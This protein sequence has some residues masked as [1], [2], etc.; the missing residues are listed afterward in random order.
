MRGRQTRDIFILLTVLL[1]LLL[2]L[3]ELL[4][5][6]NV[7][8]LLL[9]EETVDLLLDFALDLLFIDFEQLLMRARVSLSGHI[10]PQ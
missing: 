10:A 3:P 1:L 8:G 5:S 6:H 2:F 7:V 9:I 4:K